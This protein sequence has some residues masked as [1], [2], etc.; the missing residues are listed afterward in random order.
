MKG[1]LR[2]DKVLSLFLYIV[3]VFGS[4]FGDRW[5][6]GGGGGGKVLRTIEFSNDSFHPPSFPRPLHPSLFFFFSSPSTSWNIVSPFFYRA[7]RPIRDYCERKNFAS[8][9]YCLPTLWN[10]TRGTHRWHLYTV[11]L[12]PSFPLSLSPFLSLFFSLP[13]L[14]SLLTFPFFVFFSIF[15]RVKMRW[16]RS[17]RRLL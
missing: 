10:C 14:F 11:F 2:K 7:I 12:S 6:D 4:R 17:V 5:W 13:L 15:F 8:L 16:T 1:G 3:S 9:C